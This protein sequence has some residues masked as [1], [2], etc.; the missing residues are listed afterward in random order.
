MRYIVDIEGNNLMGPGLDYSAM[1]YKLKEDYRVWCIV[2][3]GL[4]DAS[5]VSLYGKTLTK[6]HLQKALANCTELIGHN[7][8]GF[9]LPVLQLYGLLDYKVGY[10][11]K[12][13][14]L[15]GKDCK[16]TDTL[17]W[18][19]LLNADR[20][21]GHSLE[22]W[23]KRLGKLKQDFS[24]FSQFSQTM[25]EYCQQDT[26]VNEELLYELLAEKAVHNWERAYSVEV[27]LADLTLKQEHFG[28]HFNQKKAYKNLDELGK[29]MQEISDKVNPLLP[30]KE[31]TQVELKNYTLPKIKFKQNGEISAIFVK[32][33]QKHNATLSE[34][35][36]TILYEG[37][38]HPI[39][40]T[41]ALKTHKIAS[42][43][44]IDVVKSYLL[45]LGWTPIE[46]KERDLVKKADKSQ[47]TPEEISDTIARYVKQTEGSLFKELRLDTI[48][49]SI[50]NLEVYL[51]SKIDGNRPIYVPTN[52][53]L[54]IGLEKEICPN[55]V[56]LGEKAD[57]V[58]DV[59]H[60]FTYRH[61]RNSIAGGFVL[62]ADEDDEPTT[63]FLSCVRVD[64]RIPTPADTLGANT[65]R[66]R[67]KIVCNV[68]RNTSLYGQEMRDLFECGKGLYQL[69][70]DFASL[71]ARIMGHY[72]I[73]YKDGQALAESLVAVKPF[74]VHSLNAAKLG[75]KRDQ[76][77]N[78]SY[79]CLPMHTRVLTK[80]G[81]QTYDSLSEGDT[82]L[83]YN[84]DKD[85]VEEDVIL[86]KHF[87]PAQEVYKYGNK[88]TGFECTE[89]HRWYGKRRSKT[90][91]KPNKF[92]F[93]F[94]EAKD[95]TTE[96]NLLLSAPWV[97][98]SS[99]VTEDE[100]ALL[101]WVLSDGYYAW[102]KRSERTSASLGKRKQL[103]MSITQANSKFWR[104]IEA[105]L[106][107]MQIPYGKFNKIQK[108]GNTV[109][110][111][112]IS[113]IWARPF[114]DRLFTVRQDKHEVDWSKWVLT[115]SQEALESFYNAF[116]K[117]DGNTKGT[118]EIVTQNTGSILDALVI[119][120]QLLGKGQVR[121]SDKTEKCRTMRITKTRFMTGQRLTKKFKKIEDT[122]CLTTKNSTFI[123]WQDNFVGITGNCMYGA[124]PKKIGKMLGISESE[125]KV[126]YN[127]YWDA[128]PAL[129]ELKEKLED[130]WKKN[131]KKYIVGLDG[132]KLFTR[133]QH[134]LINVLFQSGGAVTAK[135]SAVYLAERLEEKGI[136]GDPFMH[137]IA[138]PKV[139]WMIHMHDEQQFAVH[140]SLMNIKNFPDDEAAKAAMQPGCSAIGHGS[141]GVYMAFETEPTKCIT[142]AIAQA[143]VDM[144]LRVQI[145]HE[146]VTGLS[147]GM[148]H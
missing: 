40:T 138:E 60:Y 147:W 55:L 25:L 124:Q 39:A 126:L 139:W 144:K 4:D 34:D 72:V 102:S 116:Y 127:N 75:I 145:G 17:L 123:I 129:K 132:R 24:D 115:L 142:E 51:R 56:A 79:A 20:Y 87:N 85:L 73:P 86:K 70:Y 110:Q 148:C 104:D 13:H 77:K 50:E 19:K 27:K 133:S 108:N 84:K 125:G 106:E 109:Y 98:G 96:H 54:T 95:L 103:T 35:Q 38:D 11:G 119:V 130:S 97:G 52:P 76:A 31:M 107:R 89:D 7:I 140:P 23:G 94:T 74:D 21:G 26:A 18:S 112:S 134:S 5:L 47:K 99:S 81:W 12:A 62:D 141:K 30:M 100:A 33:L 82:I 91:G 43:D 92:V 143:N 45:S 1:P 101:G 61:R 146:W 49:C 117:G 120:M 59:V 3:R 83:T 15:Y 93:D 88:F 90:K 37:K 118:H 78:V 113:S 128:V 16:L 67:H 48:G 131:G 6:E 44:D 68:P 9:D 58:Q 14:K 42:V 46:I 66:Y 57:F 2:I 135:W 71:E 36:T 122:F 65:G 80:N 29:M 105:L 114:M 8:I 28:F 63:G 53:R 41:E 69:G 136:L 32:F 137:T 121:F 111:Y 64:G 22:A 10:P